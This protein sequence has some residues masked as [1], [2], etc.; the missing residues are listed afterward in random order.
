MIEACSAVLLR[1]WQSGKIR[2]NKQVPVFSRKPVVPIYFS[3]PRS[4]FLFGNL[5]NSFFDETLLFRQPEA[6]RRIF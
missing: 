1:K 5:P 2:S 4:K 6:K 3:R